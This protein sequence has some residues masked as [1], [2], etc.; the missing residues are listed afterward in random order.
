MVRVE[1]SMAGR[2]SHTVQVADK[3]NDVQLC[4]LEELRSQPGLERATDSTVRSERHG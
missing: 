3:S 2:A 1:I 4:G